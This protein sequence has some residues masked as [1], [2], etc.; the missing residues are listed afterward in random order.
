VLHRVQ[1]AQLRCPTA[2]P[3]HAYMHTKHTEMVQAALHMCTSPESIQFE[4]ECN[5]R[6]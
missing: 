3:L 6:G 5:W 1:P 2:P 4:V